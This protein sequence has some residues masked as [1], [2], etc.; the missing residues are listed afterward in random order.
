VGET[1]RDSLE[2]ERQSVSPKLLAHR[3]IGSDWLHR[4]NEPHSALP[5][6][7]D[8]SRIVAQLGR[9]PCLGALIGST[10]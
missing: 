10:G 4:N 5:A 7:I 6:A 8:G 9:Y 1:L 3:H 2:T